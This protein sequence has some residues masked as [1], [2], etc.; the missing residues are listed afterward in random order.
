LRVTQPAE[1]I[2]TVSRKK[3][4]ANLSVCESIEDVERLSS[5]GRANRDILRE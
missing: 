1:S 5:G 2:D 4:I 3:A